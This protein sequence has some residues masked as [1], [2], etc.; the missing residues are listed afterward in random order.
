M[1]SWDGNSI[2]PL[3]MYVFTMEPKIQS[4]FIEGTKAGS[5]CLNDTIMQY[6]SKKTHR[7]CYTKMVKDARYLGRWCM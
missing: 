4:L 6:A 2:E 7:M 1:A 5:M 3:V